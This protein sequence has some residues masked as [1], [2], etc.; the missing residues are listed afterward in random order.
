MIQTIV[1]FLMNNWRILL[2]IYAIG[3]LLTFIGVSLFWVWVIRAEDKEREL[4]PEEFMDEPGGLALQLMV[5][6]ITATVAA[7][8]WVGIP[9]VLAFVLIFD[10]MQNTFPE[11]M[12][13]MNED[14]EEEKDND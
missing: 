7:V 8:I 14:F 2:L 6:L 3:A 11:L 4:Y 5:A 1:Q 9:L 12:G 10:K 13:Y